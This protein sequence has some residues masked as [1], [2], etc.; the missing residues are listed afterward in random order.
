MIFID[1]NHVNLYLYALLI[2]NLLILITLYPHLL[3][4]FVTI[5]ILSSTIIIIFSS[6][7][8]S[9]AIYIDLSSYL[10]YPIFEYYYISIHL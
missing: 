1:I 8:Y 6:I 9:I 5:T 7:L 10:I 4:Y 3:S 2:F